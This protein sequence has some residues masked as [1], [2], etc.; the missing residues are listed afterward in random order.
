MRF[1]PRLTA[2]FQASRHRTTSK[3]RD[4]ALNP[5]IG[6][7]S[8][9]LRLLS[10]IVMF[11]TPAALVSLLQGLDLANRD[12][13]AATERLVQTAHAAAVDS[14][15]VI[16]SAEQIL[17]SL[18]NQE[19]V[20][21]GGPNCSQLLAT[22]LTDRTY[23]TDLARIDAHGN[24]VCTSSKT[25]AE[26]N[27]SGR[28]WWQEATKRWY[29]FVTPQ[30]FSITTQRPVLAGVLPLRSSSG[31]FQGVMTI[32]LDVSWLDFLLHSMS[33]T[34]GSVV[35][36]FDSAGTMIASNDDAAAA[37]IFGTKTAAINGNGSIMSAGDVNGAAWS[38]SV[39]PMAAG[40]A[41]IGFAMPNNELFAS[42]YLHVGADLLLP[43]LM[44]LAAISIWIATD[45]Q[46]TRW[47]VYLRRVAAIYA[48]GH[49]AIRP[50]LEGAPKEF[51]A[52]G[53]AF[54]SMA[55][56]VQD[57]DRSLR[58]AIEQKSLMI[59]EIHHRVK[60]NLQIV[61]SLLSLQAGKVRDPAAQ[62]ALK[63]AQIRV[64]ALA[65]VHRILHNVEEQ[66]TVD[67]KSLLEDLSVQIQEGFGAERRDIRLEVDV[68]SKRV[69]GDIA[70][71]LTL[72]TVEV[73]TNAF[74]HAYPAPGPEGLIKISLQPAGD[75]MFRLAAEDDGVGCSETA[76]QNGIGW[77]L[78]Q[79]F[80]QQVGGN[81]SIGARESGGTIVEL[82]FPD[83]LPVSPPI[84]VK[85]PA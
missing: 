84:Q 21:Q 45:R 8:L 17:R 23:F 71:P 31:E 51:R 35:A 83:P 73:L 1:W 52:L 85:T 68:I 34:M 24:V 13:A 44:A 59:K 48:R 25:E 65:L 5:E 75:G 66:G 19:E 28:P 57:R 64:N 29:F 9:R 78:I 63:Q 14:E 67:V 79:A 69:P 3:D 39:T 60:N 53:E 20:R 33:V 74:K 37:S 62:N 18:V 36:V 56:A 43:V 42:T 82:V 26:P 49:Y 2:W 32:A 50:A 47:I 61:M 46:V 22:A 70:V 4:E 81:V 40:N 38:Y 72:F 15:N 7:R 77:R 54:S 16:A 55:T 80:A 30:I 76:S 58:E 11:L 27:V 6:G 10:L 41:F 12:A